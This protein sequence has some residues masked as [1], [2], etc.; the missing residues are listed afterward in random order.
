[1]CYY[2]TVPSSS[3]SCWRINSTYIHILPIRTFFGLAP[4]PN[5][6]L[7]FGS[8][9]NQQNSQYSNSVWTENISNLAKNCG[10]IF[11]S[12]FIWIRIRKKA[13]VGPAPVW[14]APVQQQFTWLS[15]FWTIIHFDKFAKMY[16]RFWAETKI[17]NTKIN[18]S[19]IC[20]VHCTVLYCTVPD[21]PFL[22]IDVHI[23]YSTVL[24]QYTYFM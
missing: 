8:G 2:S 21:R 17:L 13:L 10:F 7:I 18:H 5:F 16:Y 9:S 22:Y 15:L 1:M 11:W 3:P 12:F 23:L 4:D 20:T 24:A 6:F 19:D 14:P